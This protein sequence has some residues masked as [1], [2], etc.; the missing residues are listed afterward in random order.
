MGCLQGLDCTV[1]HQRD[2]RGLPDE[3]L[4]LLVPRHEVRFGVDFHDRGC[5]A[6]RLDGDQPFG[7]H[8]PGFL[9]CLGESLFA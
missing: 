3:G 2:L 9:G 7:G 6:R 1:A 8:A 5:A 4:E